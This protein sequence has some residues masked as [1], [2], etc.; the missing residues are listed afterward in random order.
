MNLKELKQLDSS[1]L[2]LNW[3]DGHPGVVSLRGL[4]D[5]CPCAGCQGETVLLKQYVPPEPDT[6]APGRSALA[7]ALPVGSYAI[8]FSWR[9]GHDQGIYTWDH[10]RSLCECSACIE[11]RGGEP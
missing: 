2:S 10:L 7:G 6:E 9:D 3:D 1:K 11:R 4:R 5:G 8:R